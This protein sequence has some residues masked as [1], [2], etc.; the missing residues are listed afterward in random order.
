[1]S[2]GYIILFKAVACPLPSCFT[3]TCGVLEEPSGPCVPSVVQNSQ[4]DPLV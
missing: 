4:E 1:M 2:Y 3:P